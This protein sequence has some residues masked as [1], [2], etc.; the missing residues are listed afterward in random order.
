LPR[1]EG[2]RQGHDHRDRTSDGVPE[3]DEN[4]VDEIRH[5]GR[6]HDRRYEPG[7]QRD[8]ELTPSILSPPPTNRWQ[9]DEHGTDEPDADTDRERDTMRH[10]VILTGQASLRNT[11]AGERR[12]LGFGLALPVDP[13]RSYVHGADSLDDPALPP[14]P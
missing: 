12:W 9:V 4:R 6:S 7:R 11:R 2:H 1:R 13:R 3:E 5:K 10:D 14:H 8:T